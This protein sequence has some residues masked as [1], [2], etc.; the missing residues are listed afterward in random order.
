MSETYSASLE[1]ANNA[2]TYLFVAEMA[3]KTAGLGCR[4]YWANR[5]HGADGALA[6]EAAPRHPHPRARAR[7]HPGM[8]STAR[9]SSRPCWR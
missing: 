2:I 5:W 4:D 1:A 3:I 8:R 7:P 9:S 6:L